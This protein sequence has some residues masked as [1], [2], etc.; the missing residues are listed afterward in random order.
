MHLTYAMKEAK[1][2]DYKKKEAFDMVYTLHK[3]KHYLLG[4]KVVFYIDHM[5]MIH[6]NKLPQVSNC[7]AYL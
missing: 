1:S 2:Y 5:A 3:F 6:L 7:I 4:N